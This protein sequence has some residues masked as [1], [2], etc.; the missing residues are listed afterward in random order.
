MELVTACKSVILQE[1]FDLA[2]HLVV[3]VLAAR[4]SDKTDYAEGHRDHSHDTV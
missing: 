2:V 3:D 1:H 4:T